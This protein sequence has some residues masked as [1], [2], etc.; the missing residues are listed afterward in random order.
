MYHEL[1][2]HELH[3]PNL[4]IQPLADID[5]THEYFHDYRRNATAQKFCDNDELEA[6][7]E[8]QK[9]SPGILMIVE[10]EDVTVDMTNVN[11]LT[12]T[13]T[14]TLNKQGLKVLK[15]ETSTT[16]Q[17]SAVVLFLA[18]GYVVARTL[19]EV[20]YC[21]IDIHFWSSFEKHEGAKQ[22]LVKALNGNKQARSSSSYR[23]VAGGMFGV[24]TWRADTQLR[25]PR[26][27]QTCERE[28]VVDRP[29]S[30]DT[31]LADTVLQQS[32]QFLTDNDAMVVVLCGNTLE[33]CSSVPIVKQHST[34]SKVIPLTSCVAN[35]AN[36]FDE[37]AM[38][39]MRECERQVYQLL[40]TERGDAKIRALVVDPRAT[41]SFARIV[42]KVFKAKKSR[43]LTHDFAALAVML[44]PDQEWRRHL[45][46][47]FR[48]DVILWDFNFRTEV[49]FHS[50]TATLELD[51]TSGGDE[52]FVKRL[53]AITETIASETGL[54]VDVRDVK[55]G[56]FYKDPDWEW[57]HFF[58]PEDY[59]QTA[60]LENWKSQQPV[61]HQSVMQLE[62]KSEK[63]KVDFSMEIITKA[64]QETL[65][66]LESV[67]SDDKESLKTADFYHAP[68]GVGDGGLVTAMWKG[69]NCVALW[70]G[71]DHIDLNLFTFQESQ[72]LH[73]EFVLQFRTYFRMKLAIALR[74]TQ[75]RGYGRVVNFPSDIGDRS[76]PHW[77]KFKDKA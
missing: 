26:V 57:S 11:K 8:E 60:P 9:R 20:K 22:A 51:V 15:T 64:L 77:A 33:E 14:N 2:E 47:R 39:Q 6:V 31:T 24:D 30:L 75:P 58:L 41:H 13:L 36:E 67:S 71:R 52:G 72:E 76:D 34:V 56:L 63:T 46:E 7:P 49:E 43:F 35:V 50:E 40:Q 59:D 17:G 70:N 74:D 27:T 19:P 61:G 1:T 4:Y 23:I 48:K 44:S 69:G 12:K 55:G 28:P 10:V 54:E 18:Q 25:G 53:L 65:N 45:M 37:G 38:E 66:K 21:A 68:D 42:Y 73:D 3:A 5:D 62:P 29:G 32:L 16:D